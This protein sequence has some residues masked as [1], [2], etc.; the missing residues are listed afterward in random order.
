[1]ISLK[2]LEQAMC[3]DEALPKLLRKH[4]SHHAGHAFDETAG[5]IAIVKELFPS[6]PKS[7][8]PLGD[9]KAAFKRA[10]K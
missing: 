7:E 9:F 8:I 3:K 2:E 6:L 4:A 1:M 5:R 10:P